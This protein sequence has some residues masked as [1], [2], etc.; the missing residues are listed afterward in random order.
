MYSDEDIIGKESVSVT[1]ELDD[2]DHF[3]FSCHNDLYADYITSD[4]AGVTDL[5]AEVS[6]LSQIY[7]PTDNV[8]FTF[9]AATAASPIIHVLDPYYNF[10]VTRSMSFDSITF[11]GIDALATLASTTD[12][13]TI[14]P[15][16]K[17]PVTKCTITE[18]YLCDSLPQRECES[19][20]KTDEPMAETWGNHL[21]LDLVVTTPG[22][23]DGLFACT[24]TDFATATPPMT[25]EVACTA[26]EDTDTI[27]SVRS[28]PGEPYHEDFFTF[29]SVTGVPF[30]RHKVLFNLY[31]F[32]LLASNSATTQ[33]ASLTF[34]DCAFKYFLADYEGLIHIETNN[35]AIVEPA[36]E[37]ANTIVL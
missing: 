35:M 23:I 7:P 20:A 34:T 9:T 12:I 36:D 25:D 18:V 6:S 19:V 2:G 14:P 15:L 24:D 31:N 1:V 3:I 28:C 10:N 5:C 13:P 8:S 32:D 4:S 27:E 29:D 26:T 37:D 22:D 16:A 11:T 33:Y 21:G 30:K 17:I